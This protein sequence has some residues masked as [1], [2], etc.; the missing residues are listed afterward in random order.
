MDP[1]RCVATIGTD[2]IEI[3]RRKVSLQITSRPNESI[4]NAVFIKWRYRVTHQHDLCR[5]LIRWRER[6]RETEREVAVQYFYFYFFSLGNQRS[7]VS[8]IHGGFDFDVAENNNAIYGSHSLTTDPPRL[9]R[10]MRADLP[11]LLLHL[12]DPRCT[13]RAC[14]FY[15]ALF[16]SIFLFLE[17]KCAMRGAVAHVSSRVEFLL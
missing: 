15:R 14:R 10:S 13:L 17:K 5:F 1:E 2:Y 11:V 4:K 7:S 6:E 9:R 3:A 12:R 16:I 8:G